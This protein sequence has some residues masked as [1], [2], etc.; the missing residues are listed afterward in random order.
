MR[1]CDRHTSLYLSPATVV[2]LRELAKAHGYIIHRGVGSSEGLG[3]VSQM[4]VAVEC[5]EVALVLLADEQ[6][7]MAIEALG[8]MREEWAQD[9]AR[10]LS[11]ARAREA[12]EPGE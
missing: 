5:G 12:E 2:G 11:S 1:N 10:A 8:A 9:I 7:D 4:L 3:S 6:R